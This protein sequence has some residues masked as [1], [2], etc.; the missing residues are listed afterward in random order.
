M[1]IKFIIFII[2]T[3]FYAAGKMFGF[4]T[5]QQ[6]AQNLTEW[7]PSSAGRVPHNAFRAGFDMEQ[8]PLYICRAWHEN[9]LIPGKVVP[10]RIT[11]YVSHGGKEHCKENFDVLCG[12][13]FA[14]K[15]THGHH[16]VHVPVSAV[17]AGHTV[18]GETLYVGRVRHEGVDVVG[19]VFFFIQIFIW[20]SCVFKS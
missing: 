2:K 10:S 14:W 5:P 17:A 1:L 20:Y 7:L 11:A 6:N 15:P 18:D 3:K 13:S 12:D 19:K 16:L 8:R 4:R 9:D